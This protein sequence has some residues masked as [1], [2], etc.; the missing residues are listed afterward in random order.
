MINGKFEAAGRFSAMAVALALLG[1]AAP[2]G[3]RA[4][5]PAAVETKAG[6]EAGAATEP[7][8]DAAAEPGGAAP[9]AA[10]AEEPAPPTPIAKPDPAAPATP[11]PDPDKA[12]PAKT[13]PAKTGPAPSEVAQGPLT[14]VSWGGVYSKSQQEAIFHPF[15]RATGIEIKDKVYAGTLDQIRSQQAEGAMTWDVVDV[16]PADAEAGCEEGLF[17]KLSFVLPAAPDGTPALDDF[18]P[19]T[20]HPCA[21][22]S[23]A[24]SMVLARAGSEDAAPADDLRPDSLADFF[25][26]QT[27]PGG[28]GLRR[29]PMANLE[30]ALL[31]DGIAPEEVYSLLRTDA[32]VKR[33]LAKLD[34]IREAI[35]WWEDAGEPAALLTSGQVVMSSAYNAPAFNDIAVRQRPVELIWDRQL[36]DIDLWAVPA[37]APHREAA[38]E[39]VRFATGTEPLARQTRWLPYGPVRRSAAPLAGDFVHTDIDIAPYLPTTPENLET[40]LRNDAVFWRE[41][42]PALVDRFNDWLSR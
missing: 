11:T 14:V 30:W 42:G 39:F 31:A 29:T 25:D 18:L 5:E 3:A 16:D 19:G 40:A 33:A 21:I 1:A 20:I 15:T 2:E 41:E 27:F 36:W 9:A 7:A 38:L 10:P 22:G 35:V 28:R 6:T 4:Q 8:G 24:W 37:G 13:D 26:L 34:T 17:E 23:V 12:D 32:G